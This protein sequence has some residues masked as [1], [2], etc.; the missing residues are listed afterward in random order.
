MPPYKS[1]AQQRFFHTQTAKNKGIKPSVV[2]EFDKE[3]K[4][5]KLPEHSGNYKFNKMKN[6]LK[7]SK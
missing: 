6:S 3:S 5:M 1:L 2:N 7:G 4:G